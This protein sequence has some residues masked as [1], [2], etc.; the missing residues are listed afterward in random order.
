MARNI[1]TASCLLI[2]LFLNLFLHSNRIIGGDCLVAVIVAIGGICR[3]DGIVVTGI[4]TI[5]TTII[6]TI[7]SILD[8]IRIRG[9]HTR[10]PAGLR[11]ILTR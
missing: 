4:I 7:G 1:G 2:I 9:D 6:G 10:L 5:C 8:M 3:T 11:F